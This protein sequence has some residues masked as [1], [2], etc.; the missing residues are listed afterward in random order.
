MKIFAQDNNILKCRYQSENLFLVPWGKNALRVVSRKI[1]DPELPLWALLKADAAEEACIELGEDCASIT[2]G[3]LTAKVTHESAPD[4]LS[5]AYY[6][7]RG[8]KI[9]AECEGTGALKIDRR[10]RGR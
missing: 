3:K 7:Q 6:N 8:E 5:I 1:R 10:L 4:R 9:L 2:I